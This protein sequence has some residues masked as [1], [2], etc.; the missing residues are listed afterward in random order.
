MAKLEYDESGV[1][2]SYFVIF[3]YGLFLLVA[4][5][6]LWPSDRKSECSGDPSFLVYKCFS[7][8]TR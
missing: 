8:F 2:F 7:V 4:T 1:T 3:L 6:F 5:Y